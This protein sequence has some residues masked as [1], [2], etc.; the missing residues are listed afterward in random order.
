MHE[1]KVF[2]NITVF[3]GKRTNPPNENKKQ[4]GTFDNDSTRKFKKSNKFTKKGNSKSVGTDRHT[5]SKNFHLEK[6]KQ[7]SKLVLEYRLAWFVI[8]AIVGFVVGCIVG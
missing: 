5:Q 6:F 7:L 3:G 2:E 8:G 1:N 4:V